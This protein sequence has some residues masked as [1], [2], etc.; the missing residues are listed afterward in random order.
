MKS[1]TGNLEACALYRQLGRVHL[2]STLGDL[3]ASLDPSRRDN[4]RGPA[5]ESRLDAENAGDALLLGLVV[6][7]LAQLNLGRRA[8]F[9]NLQGHDVGAPSGEAMSK[10]ASAWKSSKSMPSTIIFSPR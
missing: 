7:H 4:L 6:A 9:D 2:R 8:G 5:R 3:E 10:M 1:G